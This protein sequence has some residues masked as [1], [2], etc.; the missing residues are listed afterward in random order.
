[1]PE[2][3]NDGARFQSALVRS[4]PRTFRLAVAAESKSGGTG[5]Y[6]GVDAE[7]PARCDDRKSDAARFHVENEISQG[8]QFLAVAIFDSSPHQP[9]KW[10]PL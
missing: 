3:W 4:M 10:E 9:V 5:L 7:K 8:T 6:P 2:R 1:M